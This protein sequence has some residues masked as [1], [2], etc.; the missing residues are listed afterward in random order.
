MDTSSK[1]WLTCFDVL[2]LASDCDRCRNYRDGPYC[3]PECPESKYPDASHSC[4]PCN[5]NCRDGCTGP[6]NDIGPGACNTCHMV[7][8]DLAGNVTQCL[9]R[10]YECGTGY[11]RGFNRELQL[12]VRA[13]V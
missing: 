9:P 10:D 4:Q 2:Q 5:E 11:F 12:Y 3:V 7:L 13:T 6:D 1:P 8:M